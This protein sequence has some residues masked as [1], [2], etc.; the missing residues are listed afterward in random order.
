MSAP[1]VTQGAA[2]APGARRQRFRFGRLFKGNRAAQAGAVVVVLVVLMALLAPFVA[3]YEPE[4]IDLRARMQPP[5]AA[6]WFGTDELGRDVLS[7][8]VWGARP[9][10]L[11]G[12]VSVAMASLVG[13]L[14]GLVA[15]YAGG[16]T[17]ALIMRLMDIVLAFPLLLLALVVLSLF[18]QSLCNIM[19]AVAVASVPQYARVV[20]GSVLAVKRME[21]VEAVAS[22][23][24]GH[25]RI[26]F[27]HVLGNVLAPLIVLATV[28]VAAA[29]T[30]EAALSF[31]GFG[32]PSAATWGNIVATG[33]PYLTNAPWIATLGGLAISV[34]VLGLNLV[35]DGLRDAMDPRLKGGVSQ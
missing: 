24:A 9:S 30:V 19:V 5:S 1:V 27:R 33:R 25:L 26:L 7:R 10:L 14:L 34:T 4:A 6:H 11:V 17:D 29:I 20:R 21:Y 32:D 18:G 8:V 31:L 16:R 15:G 28:R 23:G 13:T 12:L 22:L 35:G 3:P 2:A